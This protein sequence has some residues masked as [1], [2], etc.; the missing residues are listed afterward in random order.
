MP[1]AL[2][3]A[4]DAIS[5][6]VEVEAALA[7]ARA[8]L[9]DAGFDPVDYVALVDALTLEPLAKAAGEMRIIAAA[10]IGSTRLI[11]NFAVPAKHG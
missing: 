9:K 7:E 6:G 11:D 1:K 5:S 2:Q 4:R 8:A 10:T 3:R